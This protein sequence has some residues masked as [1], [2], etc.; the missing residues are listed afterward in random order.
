M[1]CEYYGEYSC[2]GGRFMVNKIMRS[3]SGIGN[4]AIYFFKAGTSLVILALTGLYLL[5]E[6]E[7]AMGGIGIALY[8]AP[9]L[10]YILT[11]FLIFWGGT[12][13]I[14]IAEKE[15]TAGK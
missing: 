3:F 10:E 7:A 6:A 13:I 14:D 12:F 15:I 9:M 1:Y 8:Y 5:C 11:A 4:L 2:K